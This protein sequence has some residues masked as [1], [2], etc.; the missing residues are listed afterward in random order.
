MKKKIVSLL[1]TSATLLFITITLIT[2]SASAEDF[3]LDRSKIVSASDLPTYTTVDFGGKTDV[4]K[5]SNTHAKSTR[6]IRYNN[7]N[8]GPSYSAANRYLLVDCYFEKTE[9]TTT[10]YGLYVLFRSNGTT[11]DDW[12]HMYAQS[13][14]IKKPN[15]GSTALPNKWETIVID[16]QA[17]MEYLSNNSLT[18]KQLQIELP[19]TTENFYVGDVRFS[20]SAGSSG[21][22]DEKYLSVLQIINDGNETDLIKILSNDTDFALEYASLTGK[23]LYL[24][25]IDEVDVSVSA[26]SSRL[27]SNKP[28]GGYTSENFVSLFNETII[29]L[30]LNSTTDEARIKS[31]IEENADA[32]PIIFTAEYTAFNEEQKATLYDKMLMEKPYTDYADVA[33][34]FDTAYNYVK[35]STLTVFNLRKNK[36]MSASDLPTYET[37][38]FSGKTNVLKFSNTNG[39]QTKGIRYGGFNMGTEYSSVNK[40][41]LV[42]C[43]LDDA[44]TSTFS[45]GVV[46]RHVVNGDKWINSEPANSRSSGNYEANSWVTVAID[47]QIPLNYLVTNNYTLDQLQINIPATNGN[48]YVGSVRFTDDEIPYE[49]KKTYILDRSKIVTKNSDNPDLPTYETVDFGG[50]TGVM[51]FKEINLI[52]TQAIR[53]DNLKIDKALVGTN[54]YLLIDCYLEDSERSEFGLKTSFR[55]TTSE[56]WIN[57]ESVNT[58]ISPVYPANQWVTVAI[59]CGEPLEYLEKNSY[60]LKQLQID[61][62]NVKGNLY[63]G[64]VGFVGF[65]EDVSVALFEGDDACEWKNGNLKAKI[66]FS[67]EFTPREITAYASIYEI[68]AKKI[69]ATSIKQ[70]KSVVSQG[71]TVELPIT[72]SD[73]NNSY[74]KVIIVDNR[75]KPICEGKT[76]G[77]VSDNDYETKSDKSKLFYLNEAEY[78]GQN[79]RISGEDNNSHYSQITAVIKR[80]NEVLFVDS[81][82][83]N[84]NNGFSFEFD[85][86]CSFAGDGTK[87]TSSGV[88]TA[89]ISSDFADS[90]LEDKIGIANAISYAEAVDIINSQVKSDIIALFAKNTEDESSFLRHISLVAKNL[91]IDEITENA[92]END[93]ADLLIS[94]KPSGGY[95]TENLVVIF[96]KIVTEKIFETADKE[97]KYNLIKNER[98]SSVLG[99]ETIAKRKAYGM[100]ADNTQRGTVFDGISPSDADFAD[101]LSE[102]VI[103]LALNSTENSSDIKEIIEEN[104]DK[105]LI[106][107][108]A[109]YT[110]LTQTQIKTLYANMLLKK[111]YV[112]YSDIVSK[113]NSAYNDAKQVTQNPTYSAGTGASGGGGKGF[114]VSASP[115]SGTSEGAGRTSKFSDVENLTWGKKEINALTNLG[116]I[117]GMSDDEFAPD[118]S[119]TR[120]QFCRLIVEAYQI[121]GTSEIPFGDVDDKAWYAESIKALYANNLINGISETSFGIGGRITRQDAAVILYNV[122]KDKLASGYGGKRFF[123]EDSI[124]DYAKSAV[125]AM[126][127]VGIINGYDDNTFGSKKEITRREAAIVLYR[128]LELYR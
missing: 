107:F 21:S 41:L 96:N 55:Q 33:T 74:M 24:D 91:Y 30:S 65:T 87:S 23:G 60:S 85:G 111:Q 69:V 25:K 75:N 22:T 17:A 36:I 113:F 38:D 104:A 97:E 118:N 7:L 32:I 92:I 28:I 40:T 86:Q 20:D 59:Y 19:D 42:D 79:I 57:S 16:C 48:F 45:L 103:V 3:I 26:V 106:T 10:P 29:I 78:E 114:A 5:F 81:Q 6:V 73:A 128:A 54:G 71:E 9:A 58:Q 76:F 116:I 34:K 105:I 95:T 52:Q 56:K 83:V 98:Y 93:I 44:G 8:M 14:S 18:Q 88:Y 94:R 84:E 66:T 11:T 108:D 68:Q 100:L 80:G 4:M 72:V 123:D 99:A 101:K 50:R 46:F 64:E 12:T 63:V 120:E 49:A 51:K 115:S 90:I 43:Y 119:I 112:D 13:D 27:I 67:D 77:R 82:K 117:S 1:L 70:L 122:I 126:S 110:N 62:P 61:L 125:M 89:Y 47:C 37:V 124:S 15:S 102:N 39:V 31:L 53:Y 121:K 109:D 2:M 35:N 127:S